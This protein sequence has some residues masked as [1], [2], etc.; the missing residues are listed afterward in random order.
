MKWLLIIVGLAAL[1]V[2]GLD[3]AFRLL[4][5]ADSMLHDAYTRSVAPAVER[6]LQ[7]GHA[8]GR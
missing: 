2:V 6:K 3:N 5:A 7:Q 1:H 4:D 8:H